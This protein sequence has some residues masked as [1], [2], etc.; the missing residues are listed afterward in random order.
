MC[1]EFKLEILKLSF[2]NSIELIVWRYLDFYSYFY[3]GDYE[4]L[5]VV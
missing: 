5:C 4:F 2:I 3:L 1:R